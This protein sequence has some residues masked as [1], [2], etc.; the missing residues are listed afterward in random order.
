MRKTYMTPALVS[1]GDAVAL[2]CTTNAGCGD[3]LENFECMV[4]GSLG[5]NL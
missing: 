5:F 1:R 2:T 3:P 4:A